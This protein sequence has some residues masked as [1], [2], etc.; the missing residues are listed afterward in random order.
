MKDGIRATKIPAVQPF[1]N[2]KIIKT[3]ISLII[4]SILQINPNIQVDNNICLGY[5]SYLPRTILFN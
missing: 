1:R 4:T 5:K 2:L 3:V